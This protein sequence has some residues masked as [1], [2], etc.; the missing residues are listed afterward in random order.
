MWTTQCQNSLESIK[1][2]LIRPPI[3]NIPDL[4]KIFVL[5]TDASNMAVGAALLQEQNGFLLPCL[6]A[7]RKLK[8]RETKYCI[9]EKELLGLVFGLKTFNRFL[10][11]RPFIVQTD[12]AAL[13]YLKLHA[14]KNSRLARTA[15]AIQD[16][17]FAVEHLP[18]KRNVLCDFL[19]RAEIS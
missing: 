16:Y 2:A 4:T 7:S 10:V 18:G 5:Q 15:L 13:S 17:T 14:S 6:Y 19:S 11:M 8:D 9:S 1:T 12:H 3:L